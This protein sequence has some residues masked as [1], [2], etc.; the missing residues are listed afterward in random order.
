MYEDTKSGDR[1]RDLISRRAIKM[2][3]FAKLSGV[4][5]ATLSRYLNNKMPISEKYA[6]KAAEL[7]FVSAD[8]IMCRTDDPMPSEQ[9]LSQRQKMTDYNYQQYMFERLGDFL[10][11]YGIDCKNDNHEDGKSTVT[12]NYQGK[13]VQ[14]GVDEYQR[15]LLN[16]LAHIDLNIQ[17]MFGLSYPVSLSVIN[18]L[19]ENY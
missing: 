1:L 18:T 6:K 5:P 9:R 3:Q 15:W 4:Y 13:L 16:L 11:D 12:L 2:K 8:Y 19:S 7:L 14:L 10:H 17:Q